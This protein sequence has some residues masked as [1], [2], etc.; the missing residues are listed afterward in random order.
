MKLR[1]ATPADIE[2]MMAVAQAS[3]SAAHWTAEQY[4]DIFANESA[5][6]LAVLATDPSSVGKENVV[7]FLVARQIAAEWEL[8]NIV[9]AASAKRRGIGRQLLD[10]LIKTAHET[11]SD[12]LFLEVRES[13]V[14]AR[15]LYESAGFV[16]N[17]RR[18]GYYPD[19]IED[20]ILYRLAPR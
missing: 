5:T 2:P 10:F 14:P 3:S 4:R 15:R 20:A 12:M 6:R 8:E 17:G 18:K 7:G 9:V 1:P 19:P 11:N 16:E 13:N